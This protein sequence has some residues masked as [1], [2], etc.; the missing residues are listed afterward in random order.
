MRWQN[1]HCSHTSYASVP[2]FR[3]FSDCWH[4]AWHALGPCGRKL[5]AP[6]A[7]LQGWCSC[8]NG[9][10]AREVQTAQCGDKAWV[11]SCTVW[12]HWFSEVMGMHLSYL[13]P[14]TSENLVHQ[15]VLAPT[16]TFNPRDSPAAASAIMC[17]WSIKL[18]RNLKT[19]ATGRSG[20]REENRRATRFW[21]QECT[22]SPASQSSLDT[23]II[24]KARFRITSEGGCALPRWVIV[25]SWPFN[26]SWWRF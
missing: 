3:N 4:A 13:H 14:V 22:L 10:V 11:V 19:W 23:L 18:A 2:R 21:R 16:S 15:A 24:I 6:G 1:G 26:W 7:R 20:R 25:E 9:D 5:R 17:D 8:M 12:S